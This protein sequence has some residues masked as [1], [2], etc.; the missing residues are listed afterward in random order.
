MVRVRSVTGERIDVPDSWESCSTE[1][2]QRIIG[3]WE[4]EKEIRERSRLGLFNLMVGME[5]TGEEDDQDLEMAIWECTRFVYEETLDFTQLPLPKSLKVGGKVIDI[6]KDLGRLRIGQNIHVRQELQ[7]VRDPNEAMSIV[8]AIYLQPIHDGGNFDFHR[9]KELEKEILRMP[10]TQ[11]Y[12]IGFFFLTKLRNYG[13]GFLHDLRRMIRMRM[14]NVQL[15]L[16]S[17]KLKD[18]I[19]SL[20]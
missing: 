8:T 1:V 9:A 12:P 19:N 4:P 14:Q 20:Q 3:Q 6:P 17:R 15:L 5:L 16:N 10:I 11:I 2:F 7:A 13:K 18:L